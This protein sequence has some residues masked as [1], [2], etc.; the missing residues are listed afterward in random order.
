VCVCV[1]G[2]VCVCVCVCVVSKTGFGC[3][4]LVIFEYRD[5]I[6]LYS[7]ELGPCSQTAHL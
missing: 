6:A 4:F 3:Y 2:C 5:V 7:H 1:C